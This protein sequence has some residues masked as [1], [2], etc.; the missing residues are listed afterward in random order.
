[1][2]KVFVDT[3]VWLRFLVADDKEKFEECKK[4][5]ILNENG[6]FKIYT[7]TIVLLEIAYTLSSFYRIEKKEIISDIKNILLARNLTLVEKT[8]FSKALEIF[9]KFNIKIADCL[10]ISQLPPKTILC[11]YD[12]DFRKMPKIKVATP[13]EIIQE[14]KC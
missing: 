4:F 9:K 13:K 14:I 8:N 7:S 11:T 12:K 6:K 10:I 3:N 5:L 1:M 2:K